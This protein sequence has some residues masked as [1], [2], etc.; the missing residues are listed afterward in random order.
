MPFHPSKPPSHFHTRQGQEVVN[1]E[2]PPMTE[3]GWYLRSDIIWAKPNPMPESVTDRP[4]KAHEYLFLLSKSER[5]YYD[6]A[7][8]AEP[9][10]AAMLSGLRRIATPTARMSMT[11]R[12]R[13]RL[14]VGRSVAMS[15]M[16]STICVRRS[17]PKSHGPRTERVRLSWM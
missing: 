5:Y 4:T 10:S 3:P 11:S 8:I 17:S 2:P 16:C 7:A 15:S 14:T 1:A 13:M 6:A 9:V 12:C